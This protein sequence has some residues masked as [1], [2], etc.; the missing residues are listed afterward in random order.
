[1][2]FNSE[3]LLQHLTALQAGEADPVRYVIAFSGG[4]DST[5]LL[6]ALAASRSSHGKELL[7]VH[8]NHHLHADSDSWQRHCEEVA[9]KHGVAFESHTVTI[10]E[11]TGQ[12]IEAAAR[13]ARY[14]VF[15]S[16]VREG[17]W[18]VSA[19]HQDDQAETLLLNLMRGSGPAGV[20]GIGV[21][22]NFCKGSLVRPLLGVSGAELIDYAQQ[23]NLEWVDDPSNLDTRFDR[24]YLRQDLMPQLADRWPGLATRLGRS[25]TL[26]GE[27]NELLQA[28]AEVD[29][30]GLGSPDRLRLSP[31]AALPVARRKNVI[32]HAIRLCGLPMPS[33][34][35]LGRVITEVLPAREDAQP[36]VQ[37]S[38]AEIR[39]YR[40][41]LYLLAGIEEPLAATGARL[42]ATGSPV[43]LGPGLGELQLQET[44]GQGIKSSLLGDGLDIR[45]RLGGEEIRP[46]GHDCT[47]KLKK[48]LQQ[49]GVVPWMRE[50]IPLLYAGTEL[51]A[52]GDLWIEAACSAEPGFIVHWKN[53]PC[54]T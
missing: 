45:F 24:N 8:V 7:A 17:D 30:L 12:G 9:R 3:T 47:H 41:H 5:V 38:G 32:R 2:P 16:I 39:R 20:A 27:A 18:L 22:Q 26:A 44:A 50:R 46:L 31:L 19:H 28:L 25:A 23:Q 48:L 49:S 11:N 21:K 15:R 52:V 54:L 29:M 4:V 35:V 36:L 14:G 40:D 51:V 37:W 13:D 43:S 10:P 42:L 33:A 34:Q 1:M 6:H 53:R